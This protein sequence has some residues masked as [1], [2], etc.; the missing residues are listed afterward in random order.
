[1]ATETK[2]HRFYV[3][4]DITANGERAYCATCDTF[5]AKE[6]L[7]SH[8]PERRTV[9]KRGRLLEVLYDGPARMRHDLSEMRKAGPAWHAKWFRDAGARNMFA[10]AEA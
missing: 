5:E 2:P 7:L 10:E 3:H 8:R 6:H 4:G 9:F 1:M